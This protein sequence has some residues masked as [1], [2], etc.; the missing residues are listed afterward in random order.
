M[1]GREGRK[2]CREKRSLRSEKERKKRMANIVIEEKQQIEK[3]D[4]N[5]LLICEITQDTC[6]KK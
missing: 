1:Q 6:N 4:V 2:T 3:C 5:Y